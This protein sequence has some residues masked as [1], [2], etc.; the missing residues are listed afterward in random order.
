MAEVTTRGR[1]HRLHELIDGLDDSEL[2]A[3]Q[4]FLE[5]LSAGVDPVLEALRRAP[6]DDEPE[7]EDER[8]ATAEARAELSNRARIREL[9]HEFEQLVGVREHG[10]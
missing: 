9:L 2:P 1:R 8:T 10:S 7:T 6:E 5:F 3:A 4:R